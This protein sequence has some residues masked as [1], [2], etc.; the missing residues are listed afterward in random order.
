MAKRHAR[1]NGKLR[2]PRSIAFL[3]TEWR[4]AQRAAK[5]VSADRGTWI[6]PGPL[7]REVGMRGVRQILHGASGN[8][9]RSV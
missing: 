4:E 7:V 2:H 3:A 1:K 8:S 9:A 6:E 5:L